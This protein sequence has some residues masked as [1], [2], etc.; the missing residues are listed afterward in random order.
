MKQAHGGILPLGTGSNGHVYKLDGILCYDERP[1]CNAYAQIFRNGMIAAASRNLLAHPHGKKLIPCGAVPR[2]V[3]E[4][5]GSAIRFYHPIGIPP[6][7]A[8]MMSL[9]NVQGF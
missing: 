1:A 9:I 6:P 5:V 2:D 4:F 8:A 7:A 3:L